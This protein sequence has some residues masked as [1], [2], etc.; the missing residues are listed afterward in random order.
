MSFHDIR[1]SL[2][3]A[4]FPYPSHSKFELLS[5]RPVLV[6]EEAPF[7]A[8]HEAG[9]TIKARLRTFELVS[10]S[11]DDDCHP[12]TVL[13]LRGLGATRE[14]HNFSFSPDIHQETLASE[15][16]TLGGD[17]KS[18]VLMEID[19]SD[20]DMAIGPYYQCLLVGLVL[21][22]ADGRLESK[23]RRL[24]RCGVFTTNRIHTLIPLHEGFEEEVVEL[25]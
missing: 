10:I 13:T 6:N 4:A 25:V 9:L 3:S 16:K 21:Q 18:L 22:R 7:G 24:K 19:H 15:W 1:G 17:A 14:L 5:V 12:S 23:C 20:P 2:H 11:C 8:V